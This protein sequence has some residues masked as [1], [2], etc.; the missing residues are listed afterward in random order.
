MSR[1]V[2]FVYVPVSLCLPS[3]FSLHPP[4][5]PLG[6]RPC[7]HYN[8]ITCPHITL[9]V[10]TRNTRFSPRSVGP[11]FF[12]LLGSRGPRIF[13]IVI[14]NSRDVYR[15]KDIARTPPKS[16]LSRRRRNRDIGCDRAPGFCRDILVLRRNIRE[17]QEFY[18]ENST[19]RM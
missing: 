17:T 19:L 18:S 8:G 14:R 10:L 5:I 4:C 3:S 16:E 9:A 7:P 6:T 15:G 11:Y 12:S 2:T 1:P 13:C